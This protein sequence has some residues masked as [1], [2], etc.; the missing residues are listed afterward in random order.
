MLTA[1][2]AVIAEAVNP[3]MLALCRRCNYFLKTAHGTGVTVELM[4][5][6]KCTYG[7]VSV[8]PF[9]LTHVSAVNTNSALPRVLALR[10]H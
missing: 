8:V 2:T 5:A 10:R 6:L 1:I 7:T 4:I 9:V 3:G